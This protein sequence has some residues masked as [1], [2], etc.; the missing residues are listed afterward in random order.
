VGII[1]INVVSSIIFLTHSFLCYLPNENIQFLLNENNVRST[2]WTKDTLKVMQW[3]IWH[4]GR[5]DGDSI[6]PNRVI[7]IIKQSKSDVVAMQETYGSGELISLALGF[8]YLT[9]NT[10]YHRGSNVSIHS[11][12]PIIEDI[13]VFQPFKCVG[14]LLKLPNGFNLAFY[15]IWLPYSADIWV[16]NIRKTMTAES[17]KEATKVSAD[18]LHKILEEI[19]DRLSDE[20]YTGIPIIIAGDFN[21]MSHRD[22]TSS[23]KEQYFHIIDWQTS[24]VIENAGFKD[25]YREVFPVVNRV[26]DSTWS[27]RF[28]VQEQ[29]RIDFIYYRGQDIKVVDASIIKT[30]PILFPSDHAAVT[31][32]FLIK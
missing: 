22:Y 12:Y 29:D 18:D 32:T 13:S 2:N 5:E 6:G 28:P 17:M 26:K 21:A 27:P 20:K 25:A 14:A 8:Y 11:R 4:G 3:N 23:A 24:K 31:S 16:E 1:L 9:R 15:S 7:D 10:D 19:K 30:H